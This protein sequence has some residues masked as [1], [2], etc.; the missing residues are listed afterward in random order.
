MSLPGVGAASGRIIVVMVIPGVGLVPPG[1]PVVVVPG[2][3]GKLTF[4]CVIAIGVDGDG[5]TT[6]ATPVVGGEVGGE[7]GAEVG[8]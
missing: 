2:T 6:I 1:V 7:V 5:G 4:G 8:G 3:T